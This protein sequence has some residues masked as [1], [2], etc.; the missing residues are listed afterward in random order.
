MSSAKRAFASGQMSQKAFKKYIATTSDN[1]TPLTLDDGGTRER[2]P[3]DRNQIDDRRFQRAGRGF[4]NAERDYGKADVGARH[5]DG[6]ITRPAYPP[7]TRIKK[8]PDKRGPGA[9]VARARRITSD[10]W[11]PAH[12]YSDPPKRQGG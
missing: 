7:E 1:S 2:G 4:E 6:N 10:E 12:W 8:Q 3:I 11:W 5:I 9:S